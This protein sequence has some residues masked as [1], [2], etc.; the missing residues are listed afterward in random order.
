MDSQ[1]SIKNEHLPTLK[2]CK[3]DFCKKLVHLNLS[4]NKISI[5]DGGF[6]CVNLRTLILSDNLIKEI[7]PRMLQRLPSL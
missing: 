3:L 4:M 6:E 5:I 2:A 7:G 1:I